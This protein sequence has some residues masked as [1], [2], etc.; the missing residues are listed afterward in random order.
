MRNC[1]GT[2]PFVRSA[3]V[4]L[5]SCL[6]TI[7]TV[8]AQIQTEGLMVNGPKSNRINFVYMSE[9]FQSSQMSTFKSRAKLINDYLFTD[10]HCSPFKE[11]RSFFNSWLIKVPSNESGITHPGTAT[12]EATSNHQPIQ[13]K[14]SYF[15]AS[16]DNG[17]IHRLV[18]VQST[19]QVLTMAGNRIPEYDQVMVLCNSPY[20]GGSGGQIAAFSDVQA[21]QV[22]QHEL[23]HSY[24]YLADEYFAL[25]FEA[26]NMTQNNNPA[27]IKWKKWLGVDNTGI[28]PYGTSGVE[29]TWYRPSQNCVMQYLGADFCAVCKQAIVDR[30][31]HDVDMIDGYS[32]STNA[33]TLMNKGNPF[34]SVTNLQTTNNAIKIKWYLNNNPVPIAQDI[35]FV[36]IPY[37]QLLPGDNVVRAE[38]KDTTLFSTNSLAAVGYVSNVTWNVSNPF[39][40]ATNLQEFSGRV[41]HTT[42]VISWKT[43]SYDETA[44]FELEKSIDGVNFKQVAVLKADRD[45]AYS[46]T[47]GSLYDAST[48]YR[49]KVYTDDAP[50][51]VSRVIRLEQPLSS[52]TYKVYQDAFARKYQVV[53][54]A[55]RNSKIGITVLDI[56][57][58][59]LMQSNVTGTSSTFTYPIDL[60]TAPAGTYFLRLQVDQKVY[61]AKLLAL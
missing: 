40:L 26:A 29:A 60:S 17:G 30:M 35:A 48:Y 37:G 42:G 8:I 22:A 45:N 41:E 50:N 12:D 49:L 18:S 13:T 14:D 11:Y 44:R 58:A 7:T 25:A 24:A 36:S 2:R 16:F 61:T 27:T 23:G 4:L 54:Q 28:Y 9:G 56:N 52:L 53:C 21:P 59:Q 55:D 33:F 38:L 5:A 1:N 34:F 46:Y 57:G 39:I 20:Y 32:P 31:H 15:K 10:D 51:Y 19:S 43:D 47:D 6:L 3:C